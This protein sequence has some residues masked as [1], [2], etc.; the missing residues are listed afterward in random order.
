MMS[1]PV[2]KHVEFL[3]FVIDCIL[4]LAFVGLKSL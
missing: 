2:P 1:P 3:I 4:L